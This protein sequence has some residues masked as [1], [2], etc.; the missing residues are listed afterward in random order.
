MKDLPHHM[1]KLNRRI[2]RSEQRLIEN[3]QENLEEE[4]IN[5]QSLQIERPREQIRKQIKSEMR[6]ETL[7]HI[8]DHSTTDEQN[9]EMKHR[10]PVF[11]RL[12]HQKAKVGAKPKKKSPRY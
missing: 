5:L 10:V 9:R 11:D 4:N 8:P 3:E 12:S 7:A 1:K 6:K 2:I